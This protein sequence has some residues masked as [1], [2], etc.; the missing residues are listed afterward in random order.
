MI[1]VSLEVECEIALCICSRRELNAWEEMA[2]T[3][4]EIQLC[5]ILNDL[6]IEADNEIFVSVV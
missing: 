6:W 1:S 3:S 2:S 5:N 4:D